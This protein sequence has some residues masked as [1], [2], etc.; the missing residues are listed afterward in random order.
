VVSRVVKIVIRGISC[1]EANMYIL[2]N[3]NWDLVED[4]KNKNVFICVRVCV[5]NYF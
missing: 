3:N 1:C 2:G 4:L 5:L